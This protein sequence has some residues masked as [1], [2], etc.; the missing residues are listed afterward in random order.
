MIS[1]HVVSTTLSKQDAFKKM[2]LQDFFLSSSL[3]QS[4]IFQLILWSFFPMS[5]NNSE[6]RYFFHL[7]PTQLNA[8]RRG[9]ARQGR[10]VRRDSK[11]ICQVSRWGPDCSLFDE[12]AGMLRWLTWQLRLFHRGDLGEHPSTGQP[13][14]S[15]TLAPYQPSISRD[16]YSHSLGPIQDVHRLCIGIPLPVS[17]S[18]KSTASSELNSTKARCCRMIYTL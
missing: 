1:S 10:S 9:N 13:F 12:K 14:P 15:G 6:G 3:V 18:A 4:F 16:F 2:I 5:R 7:R 17:L 11:S 8:D